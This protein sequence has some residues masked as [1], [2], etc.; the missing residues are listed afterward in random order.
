MKHALLV[1]IAR[2]LLHLKLL[3]LHGNG[4]WI[5]LSQTRTEENTYG[6]EKTRTEEEE[7]K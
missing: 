7:E 3:L 2:I 5:L 1:N 6:G 4:Y